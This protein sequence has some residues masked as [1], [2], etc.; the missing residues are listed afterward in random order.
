M[1]VSRWSLRKPSKIII[2]RSR[3]TGNKLDS[4]FRLPNNLLAINSFGFGGANVHAVLEANAHR[5]ATE[6]VSRTEARLAFACARTAD[7]CENILQH[8]KASETNI[9]LQGLM[10][11]NSLHPSHTHPYRGF[12][13]LNS[14]ES[15]ITVKVSTYLSVVSWS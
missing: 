11:D 7:G 8:L 15:S 10:S 1:A 4:F 9:E 3:Q 5:E 12:T 13:M 2:I 14:P 6:N